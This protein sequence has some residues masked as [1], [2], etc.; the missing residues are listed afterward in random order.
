MDNRGQINECSPTRMARLPRADV[1]GWPQLLMQS[2]HE[3]VAWLRDEAD[4]LQALSDLR[5]AAAA[6]HVVVHAYGL[7]PRRMA[8]VVTP[9][10]PEAVSLMMQAFG[11]RY[12]AAFNRRH[13]RSGTLWAGRY[14]SVIIDP[15][16]Y[17]LDAMQLVE[18]SDQESSE[19]VV[20]GSLAHHLG[21]GTDPLVNDHAA[22]WALGNTPFDRHLAWRLRLEQGLPV[23]TRDTLLKGLRTGWPLVD[24]VQVAS[25]EV[26][27]GRRLLPAQR[28]RPMKIKSDP[29]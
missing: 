2:P 14:R 4:R 23:A 18:T 12:V 29:I 7:T 25:L 9:S 20:L 5:E 8:L 15:A 26:Q 27:A 24:P 17:L 1:P 10:E 22:Y 3:G 28:G 13:G 6:C 19:A 11:R 21:Q 16:R